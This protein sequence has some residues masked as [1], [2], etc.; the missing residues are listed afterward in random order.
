MPTRQPPTS[1]RATR[2]ARGRVSARRRAHDPDPRVLGPRIGR[3]VDLTDDGVDPVAAIDDAIAALMSARQ[4][5]VK[6][7]RMRKGAGVGAGG[8]RDD[9]GRDNDRG[10]IAGDDDRAGFSSDSDAA[11]DAAGDSD[12]DA[13]AA[14]DGAGGSAMLVGEAGAKRRGEILDAVRSGDAARLRGL[15]PWRVDV[16]QSGNFGARPVMCDAASAGCSADAMEVLI[17]NGGSPVCAD[18]LGRTPI[19]HAAEAG[20]AAVLRVLLEHSGRDP[21]ELADRRGYTAM[22]AAAKGGHVDAMKAL[23]DAC[24]AAVNAQE[25]HQHTP[26][27]AAAIGGQVDAVNALLF[28][29]AD[30]SILWRKFLTA[31]RVAEKQA[32][33]LEADLDD[34]DLSARARIHSGARLPHRRVRAPHPGRSDRAGR[35]GR[36]GRAGRGGQRARVDDC[37]PPPCV[38]FPVNAFCPH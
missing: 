3:V 18:Q 24:P 17:R 28:R 35:R 30:P 11:G 13:D 20:N 22:H 16:N 7:M 1:T 2:T 26:L 21:V 37:P 27:M 19:Y 8:G 34:R 23:Y 14:G 32:R 29:G 15:L 6:A 10:S 4:D 25:R 33:S 12:S 5:A 9:G 38:F 36:A 31:D